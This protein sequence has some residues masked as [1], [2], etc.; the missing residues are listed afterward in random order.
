MLKKT[1]ILLTFF[2]FIKKMNNNNHNYFYFIH[3]NEDNINYI[4]NKVQEIN[5]KNIDFLSKLSLNIII[6]VH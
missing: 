1:L 2:N 4:N 6:F 3:T 5:I